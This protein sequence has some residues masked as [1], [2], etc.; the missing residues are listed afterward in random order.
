MYE[1]LGRRPLHVTENGQEMRTK[2]KEKQAERH[3][4]NLL[5][6][7]NVTVLPVL[8]SHPISEVISETATNQG[9]KRSGSP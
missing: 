9:K 3:S 7:R 4:E 5:S 2:D 8:R 1:E 6:F